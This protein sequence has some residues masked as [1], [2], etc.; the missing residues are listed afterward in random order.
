M[1]SIIICGKGYSFKYYKKYLNKYD[2]KIGYNQN[3]P[4]VFDYLFFTVSKESMANDINDSILLESELIIK[5]EKEQLKIGSTTF[6]LYNLIYDCIR[7]YDSCSIHLVG[8]DY[9][10]IYDSDFLINNGSD[11]QSL[12]NINSQEVLAKKLQS[13]F[14]TINI[15]FVSFDDFGSIS[16]KTGEEYYKHSNDVE[17]V[18][19]ITTNHFGSKNRLMKLIEG[20]K[21]AGADSIKLQIRDVES[22]YSIQKLN[23][24]LLLELL[25]AITVKH[26]S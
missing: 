25:L 11:L 23:I 2:I 22:F 3:I 12:V 1:K 17:I 5:N 6:G 13:I 10:L 16:P 7:R 26:W 20:A 8:F 14:S 15:Q 21:N 19:E 24:D 4:D 18:G 9:R